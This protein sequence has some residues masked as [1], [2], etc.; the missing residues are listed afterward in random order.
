MSRAR[1]QLTGLVVVITGAGRGIG[2]A[3]A[4]ALASRGARVAIGDIDGDLALQTAREIGNGAIGAPVD[5]TDHAAFTAWLDDIEHDLG[6][7]DVL[8]NNA[9]IMPVTM[10]EDETDESI[11][12]QIAINLHAV[13]HGTREAV[14]RMRPR[15]RGHIINVASLAGVIALPGVATYTATKHGVVGY[16]QSARM[17]LK[18]SGV[19]VSC[20]MPGIVKTELS[21]GMADSPLART[22]TADM[23][24]AAI[25]A[26][27]EKPKFDVIVPKEGHVAYRVKGLLPRRANEALLR[28]GNTD[29]SM[30]D[31]VGNEQRAAYEARAAR[32]I[33]KPSS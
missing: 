15:G 25:V 6:T 19:E 30:T 3:T 1:R 11:A 4:T 29:H 23:V 12:R 14:R 2:A 8:I 9:G 20:V 22:V 10:L 28:I 13:I 24:A 7:I 16:S 26:A 5:V 33:A 21:A 31:I 27:I 17:E 18:G 32:D